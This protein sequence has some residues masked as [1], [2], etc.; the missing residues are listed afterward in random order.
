MRL[1][2]LAIRESADVA[3][4]S[5]PVGAASAFDSCVVGCQCRHCAS[6][7]ALERAFRQHKRALLRLLRRRVGNEDDAA[8]I[9]QE[10]YLRLLRYEHER[11]PG[12]IRALLYR[13][14]INLVRMR[15]RE[16]QRRGG[17]DV[18]LEPN[19]EWLACG[20]PSQEQQLIDRQRLDLL[21]SAIQSLPEKCHQVFILSRFHD[22]SYPQIAERCGISVKMV[23]KHISK[24]L[25]VCRARLGDEPT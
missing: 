10:A 6:G 1:R 25:L 8:E 14:A 23:E 16:M 20:T 3:R 15:A 24:A 22:M 12:A 13:I 18:P 11:D 17:Y 5:F 9:A 4:L 2:E 19:T 21:M 7:N